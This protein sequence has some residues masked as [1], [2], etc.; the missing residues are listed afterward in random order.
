ML[1]LNTNE[2]VAYEEEVAQGSTRYCASA[3]SRNT[4]NSRTTHPHTHSIRNAHT[5]DDQDAR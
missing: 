3:F 5:R 2:E 1:V 4:V